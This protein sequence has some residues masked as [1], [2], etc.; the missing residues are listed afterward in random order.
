MIPSPRGWLPSS[1]WEEAVWKATCSMMEWLRSTAATALPDVAGY[2]K[3]NLL[4][5]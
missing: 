3:A 4:Q 2:R 1:A 5:D